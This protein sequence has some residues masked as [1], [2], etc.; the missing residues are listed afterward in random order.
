AEGQNGA[1]G[2]DES[3]QINNGGVQESLH[4]VEK[5]FSPALLDLAFKPGVEPGVVFCNRAVKV[6][7]LLLVISGGNSGEVNHRRM[8]VVVAKRFQEAV[9]RVLPLLA[10]GRKRMERRGDQRIAI[11]RHHSKILERLRD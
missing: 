3:E 11:L 4:I 7:R 2:Q 9:P 1:G 10:S 6:L 5:E 8:N